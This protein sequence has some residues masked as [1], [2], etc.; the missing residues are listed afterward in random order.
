M[1]SPDFSPE[2]IAAVYRAIHERRDMRHFLPDPVDSALL[3][4]LLLAAH[5]APSVGLCQP[6]R[7]IRIS[8]LGHVEAFYPRPLLETAQWQNRLP[9]DGLVFEN[10]W[11][12]NSEA[13]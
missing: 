10:R 9:L 8:D 11:G 12:V 1:A 7:F 6:W 3:R 4:R 13:L 2:E 5:D